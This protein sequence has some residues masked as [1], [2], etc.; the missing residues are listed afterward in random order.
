MFYLMQ[1]NIDCYVSR[2]TIA[3]RCVFA[4]FGNANVYFNIKTAPQQ[5]DKTEIMPCPLR[6]FR[7]LRKVLSKIFRWELRRM[8]VSFSNKLWKQRNIRCKTI[9]LRYDFMCVCVCTEIL[10]KQTCVF[11]TQCSLYS[12]I[13]SRTHFVYVNYFCKLSGISFPWLPPH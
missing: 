8:I 9:E 1:L 3:S 11:T 10:K 2:K 7:L 13:N 12:I 4:K 6:Y 5:T